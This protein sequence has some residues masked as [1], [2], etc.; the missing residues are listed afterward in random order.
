MMDREDI[1][2]ERFGLEPEL[3]YLQEIRSL[4]IEETNSSNTEEHEYL[5]TLC[6]LLFTFGYPDDTLLIWNAK[7]KDF[8]AGCYIDGDLLMGAGL[9]ETIHFLQKLNTPKAKEILEYIKPY[10]TN[11]DYMT[12]E[13]VID[14]YNKYYRL[15]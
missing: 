3:K 12:R 4:L 14:F 13:Q 6:I 2:L 7:R 5:K 8:D 15:T 1:L 10:K 9:N 11:Y